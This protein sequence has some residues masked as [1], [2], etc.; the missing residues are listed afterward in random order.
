MANDYLNG[1]EGSD[2]YVF[3]PGDSR[4]IICDYDSTGKSHDVLQFGEGI[5][6]CRI[7]PSAAAAAIC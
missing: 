6:A 3:D 5:S 1:G 4:D 7:S 2:T